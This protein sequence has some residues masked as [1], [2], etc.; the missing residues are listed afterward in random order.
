MNWTPPR[1][2]NMVFY[3]ENWKLILY[4]KSFSRG[5]IFYIEIQPK[6]ESFIPDYANVKH[7]IYYKTIQ[8]NIPLNKKSFGFNGIYVF[9]PELQQSNNHLIWTIIYKD[10]QLKKDIFIPVKLIQFP[11]SKRKLI[12]HKKTISPPGT[13]RNPGKSKK[14]TNLKK[15]CFFRKF[16]IYDNEQIITSKG[17]SL[18]YF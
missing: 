15:N 6:D 12:F 1:P 5:E 14:R 10:Y 9:P 7:Q 18:Y 8:R 17:F 16:A 4:S 3:L 2:Q 13:K 11:F